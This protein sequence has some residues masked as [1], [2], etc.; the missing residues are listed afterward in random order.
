M[1]AETK[2]AIRVWGRLSSSNVQAVLW[3][4]AELNLAFERINAGYIHGV[5][6]KPDYL[7]M[8]P[9]GLVPTLIDGSAPPLFETGAILRY[10]ASQYAPESFWPSNPVA[11]SQTDKWAEWAKINIALKFTAPVFWLV[12]RTAPSR[13]NPETIATNLKTLEKYLRVADSRLDANQYLAG[14]NF[15]LADIHMGHCLFRYYDIA[16]ERPHLPNLRHYYELLSTRPA[17]RKYVIASY[18]ELWV[19]DD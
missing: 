6:D 13:Q 8:N 18:E 7:A 15:T 9:N 2:T 5:V 12:V 17:Y 10:L 4:L 19:T 16:I 14:A 3:C 11:R 1:K